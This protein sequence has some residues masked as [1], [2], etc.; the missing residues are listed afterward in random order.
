MLDYM[1]IALVLMFAV[2]GAM[3]G[4][5]LQSLRLIAAGIAAWV[6][7]QYSPVIAE[8]VNLFSEAGGMKEFAWP[9]IVFTGFYLVLS[10]IAKM[11]AGG[12][13]KSNTVLSAGDRVLGALAGAVKGAVLSYFIISV[14]LAAQAGLDR[15]MVAL[16]AEKSK[17]VG[18]VA[19]H[20]FGE[21]FDKSDNTR[22]K[23]VKISI[24]EAAADA[25]AKAENLAGEGAGAAAGAVMDAAKKAA[26]Q[27]GDSVNSARQKAVDEA[28]RKIDQAGEAAGDKVRAATDSAKEAVED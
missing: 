10:L 25:A 15:Q 19:A 1:T 8:S 2:M 11:I 16:N 3:A 24:Q 23:Q 4:F 12:F 26:D 18:F 28:T 17:V 22:L 7:L 13:R 14:A 6:A 5:L 21:F 9:I 27:I 20:P